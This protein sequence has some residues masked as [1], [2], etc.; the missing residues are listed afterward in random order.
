MHK[1]SNFILHEPWRGETCYVIKLCGYGIES[2]CASMQLDYT[3]L[4]FTCR[5][6]TV[7]SCTHGG[8]FH[9]TDRN[10]I[11]CL[12]VRNIQTVIGTS[13]SRWPRMIGANFLELL[14]IRDLYEKEKKTKQTRQPVSTLGTKYNKGFRCVE[15]FSSL[16]S[17]FVACGI[18]KL[19]P[20]K[21]GTTVSPVMYMYE[22][23]CPVPQ[24]YIIYEKC[25]Q[26]SF[27]IGMS[28]FVGSD[29]IV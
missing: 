17:L 26:V 23:W 12:K 21:L 1:S 11:A 29:D 15:T 4:S 3:S 16:V 14:Y 28:F 7:Y 6:R 18:R 8:N 13:N 25:Y 24:L 27:F 2:A 19:Q 20:L 10:T 22:K 9:V 5:Y